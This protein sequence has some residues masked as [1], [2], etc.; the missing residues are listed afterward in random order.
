MHEQP[1]ISPP[2]PPHPQ[3]PPPHPQFPPQQQPYYP[4]Q[5]RRHRRHRKKRTKTSLY[6]TQVVPIV[7]EKQPLNQKVIAL[8]T[9]LDVLPGLG[10]MLGY[11]ILIGF[12]AV[13]FRLD[14]SKYQLFE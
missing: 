8:D 2:P 7:E 4:R 14:K 12:V 5:H 6:H 11:F 10:W 1:L 3:F 13:S 9:A